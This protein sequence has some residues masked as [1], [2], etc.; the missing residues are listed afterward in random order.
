M[1]KFQCHS[2]CANVHR[3]LS[4]TWQQG[5]VVTIRW[6]CNLC[7]RLETADVWPVSSWVPV[8]IIT[9]AVNAGITISFDCSHPIEMP[10]NAKLTRHFGRLDVA[11]KNLIRLAYLSLYFRYTLPLPFGR[12]LG[13]V[14]KVSASRAADMGSIPS[15]VVD[16]FKV[17]SH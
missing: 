5:R 6:V 12:L 7:S 4:H 10:M 15:F 16:L 2:Q 13:Q 9:T 3:V 1:I 11:C 17:E 8:Q 14:V